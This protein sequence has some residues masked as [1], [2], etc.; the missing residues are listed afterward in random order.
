VPLFILYGGEIV[1][2]IVGLRIGLWLWRGGIHRGHPVLDPDP[3][4]HGGRP[5]PR[6]AVTPRGHRPLRVQPALRDAA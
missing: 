3:P 4:P 2:L 5:L 6:P 1:F